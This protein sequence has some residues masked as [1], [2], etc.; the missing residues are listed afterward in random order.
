MIPLIAWQAFWI[1]AMIG[2]AMAILMVWGAA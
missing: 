2:G 1:A